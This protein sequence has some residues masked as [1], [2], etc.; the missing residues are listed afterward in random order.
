KLEFVCFCLYFCECKRKSKSELLLLM[1]MKDIKILNVLRLTHM[2]LPNLHLLGSARDGLPSPRLRCHSGGPPISRVTCVPGR[3]L[4]GPQ[5]GAEGASGLC[6]RWTRKLLSPTNSHRIVLNFTFMDTE[7]TYDYLF[8]YDGDSYQSPLLASLSGNSL[9]EPIEATSGK[10][11]GGASCTTALCSQACSLN[12]QCDKKGERC[13]CNPGFLGHICQLGLRDDNGAGQWWRVSEGNPNAPPRTGSAGVYLSSTGAMYLFG[14]FD[15]NRALGDLMKYN[16]TSSQW[17]SR[18]YGHSPDDGKQFS[19]LVGN[20]QPQLATPWCSTAHLGPCWSMEVTGLLLPGRHL[21]HPEYYYVHFNKREK[22]KK[23]SACRVDQIS[24]AYGWWGERTRFLTSLHS[25]RTENYVPGL[26]LLTFQHP[27]NDSQPDK[28][29]KMDV[30][31]QFK[32]FI[33]PLWGGP[34]PAPPPTETV[35]IWARIQRLHFEARMASGPNSTQMEISFLFLEPYRSG[36]C[37]SY[38]SCLACLSDQSCGWCP[39]LSRCLWR[40][41]PGLE[42]CPETEM[43]ESKGDGQRHLLLAPQHCTLCEEYRDC[44][45]CTQVQNKG[46]H[47]TTGPHCEHCRPGSFGSALAGGGGCIP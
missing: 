10:G 46:H 7:C 27:R 29:W 25:C 35:F 5:T 23:R 26:H 19:P 16:F 17:E 30:A 13:R 2:I 18:S 21:M 41:G 32:G 9:P 24:G 45:A 14:G 20:H 8:V 44:S 34:P 37:S 38:M 1:F 43:V 4:Q 40:D 15:L 12:G 47:W 31:L 42:N 36:S 6:H 11:W 3:G 39:S 28:V 22:E 33:H